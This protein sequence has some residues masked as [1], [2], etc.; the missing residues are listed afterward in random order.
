MSKPPNWYYAAFAANVRHL[1][2]RFTIAQSA[3]N[4]DH[5]SGVLFIVRILSNDLYLFLSLF[6]LVICAIN[7]GL[8]PVRICIFKILCIAKIFYDIIGIIITIRIA[9]SNLGFNF[10]FAETT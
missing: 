10:K 6:I 9:I 3:P 5:L 1:R 2:R 8:I 7:T 4:C